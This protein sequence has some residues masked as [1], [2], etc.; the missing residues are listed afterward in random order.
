MNYE[1]VAVWACTTPWPP[2]SLPLVLLVA[3]FACS[4]KWEQSNGNRMSLLVRQSNKILADDGQ[5]P[6]TTCTSKARRFEIAF[7]LRYS[8]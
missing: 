5:I 4:D 3:A 8:R 7:D 1:M 2:W 6:D